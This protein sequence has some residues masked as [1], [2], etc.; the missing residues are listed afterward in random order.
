MCKEN[1]GR[2]G[3]GNEVLRWGVL[4]DIEEKTT[5]QV[6]L[7]EIKKQRRRKIH[8]RMDKRE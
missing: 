5:Y 7:K 1:Q 8:L 3:V 6:K 2:D 4:E